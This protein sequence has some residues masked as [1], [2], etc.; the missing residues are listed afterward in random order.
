MTWTGCE[1][2]EESACVCMTKRE[3]KGLIPVPEVLLAR[4]ERHQAVIGDAYSC[5]QSVPGANPSCGPTRA[6]GD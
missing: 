4:P 2:T 1:Q 5:V 6:G 3:R